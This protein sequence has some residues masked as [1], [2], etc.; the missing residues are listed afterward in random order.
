MRYLCKLTFCIVF[1]DCVLNVRILY[2]LRFASDITIPWLSIEGIF[3]ISDWRSETHGFHTISYLHSGA[4]KIWYVIPSEST[5]LFEKL[6]RKSNTEFSFLTPDFLLQKSCKVKRCT[7]KEG[8]YIVIEPGC[9][10]CTLST[11]YSLSETVCFASMAWFASENF[12]KHKITENDFVRIKALLNYSVEESRATNST[13]DNRTKRAEQI[14][15][16]L[17]K[18]NELHGIVLETL[19]KLDQNDI[20]AINYSRSSKG[21]EPEFCSTCDACCY[22]FSV[23]LKNDDDDNVET[24][25]CVSHAVEMIRTKQCKSTELLVEALVSNNKITHLRE[26][27]KALL[28]TTK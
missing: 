17:D 18:I 8:Q 15:T 9:Y 3:W 25:L 27:L 26:K 14:K 19:E 2:F 1:L 13:H 4:E 16:L 10:Y 12:K 7:Q 24:I 21:N 22:L 6:N 11:G 28:P 5:L 20:K 23:H